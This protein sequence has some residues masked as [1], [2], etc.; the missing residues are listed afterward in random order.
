MA[1]L[2]AAQLFNLAID[3]LDRT[4]LANHPPADHQRAA[5]PQ[6]S[7]I[8][9]FGYTFVENS[10]HEITCPGVLH[11]GVAR[12]CTLHCV[13]RPPPGAHLDLQRTPHRIAHR[14]RLGDGRGGSWLRSVDA[15][16]SSCPCATGTA[17]PQAILGAHRRDRA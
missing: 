6:R 7:A 2:A 16:M 4:L 13:E 9:K 10:K 12:K 15:H 3:L 5:S 17:S 8:T 1:A 14:H 11:A